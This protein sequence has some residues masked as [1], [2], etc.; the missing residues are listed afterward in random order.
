MQIR[1]V[2]EL[3]YTGNDLYVLATVGDRLLSNQDDDA[4]TTLDRGLCSVAQIRLP[5]AVSVYCTY[6]A[7]QQD[8]AYLYCPEDG[9]MVVLSVA[10]EEY[11]DGR[12]FRQA[13]LA[14]CEYLMAEAPVWFRLFGR[15]ELTQ[16][17]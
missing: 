8:L 11:G 16:Q 2:G 1:K 6:K 5:Q 17:F 15:T 4:V 12:S 10:D 7:D 9:A 14:V 3:A 13:L